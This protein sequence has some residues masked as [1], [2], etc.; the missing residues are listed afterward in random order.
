MAVDANAVRN[1][2]AQ[3]NKFISQAQQASKLFMGEVVA[4]GLASKIF[5]RVYMWEVVLPDLGGIAGTE[6]SK[7]IQ[8]VDFGDYS[9]TE[10][11]V[12]RY[13]PFQNKYA[14]SFSIPPV[15]LK[16]LNPVPDIITL[17]FN[18]WKSLIVSDA[19]YFSVK[20]NYAKTMYAI[21]YDTTG[22]ETARFKM[23]GTFPKT[24]PAHHLSYKEEKIV[25]FDV[26][27]S[28]D[29]RTRIA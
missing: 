14:G 25:D 21:L 5:Q 18:Y 28:I 3:A 27:L 9:I 22:A 4:E 29:R 13:G 24:F 17:Y 23:E 2:T 26:E 15:Q 12:M 11:A 6:V 7:Y 16:I 20:S 10:L 8:D 19:G 1:Q